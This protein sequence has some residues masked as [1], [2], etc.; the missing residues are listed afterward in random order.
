MSQKTLDIVR[1]IAQAA[2]N[3]YDGAHDENG[4]PVKVGLRRE[5][6][7][8]IIDSRVVDG[9]KVKIDGSRLIVLYQSDIKLR[10]VYSTNY[11][12]VINSAFG[13]IAKYLKKEYK[14]ITGNSLSLKDAGD[15]DILIQKTS[16]V[17]VWCQATKVY[18][19]GGLDGVEDRLAPSEDRLDSEFRKF[20]GLGGWGKKAENKNQRAPQK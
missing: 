20:L 6:G 9:F 19:I 4:E 5:M 18:K 11:E 3:A 15:P 16:K 14:K 12:D 2:A 1:G 17:R 13:D 8:P 7:N 10:D